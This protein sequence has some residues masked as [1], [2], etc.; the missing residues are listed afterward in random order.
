VDRL[1]KEGKES[2]NDDPTQTAPPLVALNE[3]KEKKKGMWQ[4]PV[5][6]EKKKN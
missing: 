6:G 5:K 2:K 3:P 1:N 4:G